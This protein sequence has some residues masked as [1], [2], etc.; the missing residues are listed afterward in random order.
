MSG[1]ILLEVVT[2]TKIELRKEVD[3]LVAPTIDGI[4]GVLPGHIRL[5]TQLTT[6]ILRY[7]VDGKDQYMVVSDGF[8]EV[9]PRKV[10][11]LAEVADLAE[12]INP[13]Q[14]LA[15]K[16]EAEAAL[17]R[18]EAAGERANLAILTTNL[19]RAITRVNAAKK[20][21]DS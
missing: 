8:M 9:T 18:G 1:R 16:R 20:H 11:I 10:I 14:A 5:L 13:E 17:H 15:E 7:Q 3:Y 2:P 4:V 19:D 6:G 12:D 21:G